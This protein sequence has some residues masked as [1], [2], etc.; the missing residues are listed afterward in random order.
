MTTL[1]E[2]AEALMKEIPVEG[3]QVESDEERVEGFS[4]D[5]LEVESG[6]CVAR[7]LNA[8]DL[9]C[10][11]AELMERTA[12]AIATFIAAAPQLVRDLRD[13]LLTLQKEN[14]E[15]KEQRRSL[16]DQLSYRDLQASGGFP[17]AQEATRVDDHHISTD[18]P[19]AAKNEVI[20]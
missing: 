18:S 8:A 11:D 2:Q 19:T 4:I 3:W 9:P 20:R 12:V 7:V 10:V 5:I 13:R 1:P 6:V 15:L 14:E 17:E 16:H